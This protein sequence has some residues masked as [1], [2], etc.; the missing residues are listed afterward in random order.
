MGLT[1]EGHFASL[2]MIRSRY[3]KYINCL[4]ATALVYA[5]LPSLSQPFSVVTQLAQASFLAKQAQAHALQYASDRCLLV[6]PQHSFGYAT[7]FGPAP[8]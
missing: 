3:N 1:Y 6:A 8:L 5:T 2:V 4:Y 7:V